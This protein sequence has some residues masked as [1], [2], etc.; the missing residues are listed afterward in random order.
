MP[1]LEEGNTYQFRVRA[2]NKAGPGDPSEETM[3]HVAKPRFAKPRIDRT[4]LNNQVIKV[5]H[6]VL[7][8]VDV[9]G[10]PP[11]T[12]TWTFADKVRSLITD[13]TKSLFT[14]V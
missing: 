5:G 3:P 10:E 14:F 12:I 7:F 9:S 2:V 13:Y 6:T 4:N 11:P 8:D 1:K